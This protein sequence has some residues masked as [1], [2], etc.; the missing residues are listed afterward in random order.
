MDVAGCVEAG[1]CCD[2]LTEVSLPQVQLVRSMSEQLLAIQIGAIMEVCVYVCIG[3][4]KQDLPDLE[5]V[6][7]P[8]N[9]I[10]CD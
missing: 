10:E 3:L 5:F 1:L 9:C 8:P 6:V 7:I 2:E 4:E